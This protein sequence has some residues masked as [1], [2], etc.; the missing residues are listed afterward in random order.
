MA[1]LGPHLPRGR[2]DLEVL[3]VHPATSREDYHIPM[4]VLSL[5][6]SLRCRKRGVM[7]WELT[8]GLIRG[9]R[10]A[11]LDLHW[12]FPLALV[13]K[14]ASVLKKAN[15]KIQVVVGGSTATIFARQIIERFP[16]DY[17][18]LG[19][20]DRPF[21]E[22]VDALLAGMPVTRVANI[23]SAAGRSGST[24]AAAQGD[25]DYDQMDPIS[26]DWFPTFQERMRR[27]QREHPGEFREDLGV[28][29]FVPVVRGCRHEC[30]GCY[31]HPDVHRRLFARGMAVRSPEAVVDTLLRCERDPDVATVHMIGDFLDL[32]PEAYADPILGRKYNLHL[33][34]D[35]YNVPGLERI[36]AFRR[37][38]RSV[39]FTCHMYC[40]HGKTR[41][42]EHEA[43][44]FG[45]LAHLRA[46]ECHAAL[47][48]DFREVDLKALRAKLAS[49]PNVSLMDNSHWYIPVPYPGTDE[50]V[51]RQFEHFYALCCG[52]RGSGGAT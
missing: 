44:L 21:R 3:Y 49:L 52:Q 19:D 26:C 14:I 45:L 22:L 2:T 39:S 5:I 37:C 20:A 9:T 24:Y 7:S 41:S 33:T 28:Y 13:E 16:V 8:P 34:Y 43:R 6:N 46:K 18:V 29:P 4:G 23:A 17:V 47:F 10:V 27:V 12:Y 1:S 48:A 15:P 11:A 38:F 35:L 51:A 31:A 50:E 32:L 40:D 42:A 36:E 30:T 25:A